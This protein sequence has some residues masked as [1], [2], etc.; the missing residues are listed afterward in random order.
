MPHIVTEQITVDATRIDV[1]LAGPEVKGTGSVKSVL[2]PRKAGQGSKGSD[3]RLPSM[4]KQDQP[5][6]V[7]ADSLSY[8]GQASLATYTGNTQL[9]QSDTSIKGSAIA[10]DSQSGDLTAAGP[11]TTATAMV[12]QDKSG[13]KERVRS[14]GTAKDFKYEEAARRATYTGEAHIT[15]PQ[16]DLISP[17]IELYLKPSGDELDRAEA[18]EGVTLRADNRKTVGL[19][20]TYFGVDERYFVTGMPV[21][22]VDECG[23][24]TVGRQATYFKASERVVVDGNEQTRTQTTGKSNCP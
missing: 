7:T 20:L 18:Y 5:V 4:L 8:D 17:R 2:Q 12:Q 9:W 24:E 19:R 10:I 1:M 11:V 15:G 16:G 14:V 3:G 21:T 13:R 22:I 6:N 23:R